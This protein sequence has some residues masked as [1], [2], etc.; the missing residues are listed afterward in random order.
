M[1]DRGGPGERIGR[2]LLGLPDRLFEAWH[3][4]RRTVDPGVNGYGRPISMIAARGGG[5]LVMVGCID[6]GT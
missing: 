5:L 3:Q 1:I 4:A 6:S 2:R